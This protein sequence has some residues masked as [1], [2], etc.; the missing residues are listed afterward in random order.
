MLKIIGAIVA[1]LAVIFLFLRIK[2]QPDIAIEEAYTPLKVSSPAFG[3]NQAIPEQYSGDGMD[4]SPELNMSELDRRVVSLAV[5]MDD[6]DHPLMGVYN[7]W[8]I[9]NIP[10][11][12]TIPEAIPKGEKVSTLSGAVQGIGYGKHR[13]RGP[14]PPFGSHRYNY[15]VFALDQKLNLEASAKKADLLAAMEGHIVQYGFLVGE[16]PGK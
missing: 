16:Y 9:W 8:L 4:I 10:P 1:V 11:Q 15:H 14:K 3:P 13:Y 2:Q 7:H 5:I 6:I 12:Q